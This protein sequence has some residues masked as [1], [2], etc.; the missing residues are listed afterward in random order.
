MSTLGKQILIWFLMFV[1]T[2]LNASSVKATVSDREVIKGDSVLLTITVMGSKIERLPNIQEI[3]GIPV[4]GITRGSSSS[5]IHTNGQ[6]K[7]EHTQTITLEFVPEGN[8]TIPSFQLQVDGVTKST[9]LIELIV[10]DKVVGQKRSNDNFSLEIKVNKEKIYLGE[11]ILIRIY[12]KQRTSIDLMQIDYSPPV[13]K[14]F[15][16]KQLDGEKT[17]R[18]GGY[19]IHELNYLLTAKHEGNLTLES[20]HARVAERNRQRQMGGWYA[21]VPKWSNIHSAPK[22]IEVVKPTVAHDMVGDFRLHVAIDTQKVKANKP[23]NLQ[24]DIRGEGN[25]E[26]Y[27]GLNFDIPNVTMYSDDAKVESRLSAGKLESHYIKSFVFIANHDFTIPSRTIRV[28]NYKTGKV[29][30]LKTKAYRVKVENGTAVATV[31]LVH[32]KQA[33][34]LKSVPIGDDGNENFNMKMPSFVILAITFGLGAISLF[35]VQ[36]LLAYLPSFSVGKWRSKK[37]GFTGHDALKILYPHVG[38]SRE[39]ENMVR[40]LYAIKSGE[41]GIEIDRVALSKMIIKYKTKDL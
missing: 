38:E 11:P 34:A 22:I 17:Y 25:L 16:N 31:P 41:K 24:I 5:F 18:K 39:V 10:L 23:I 1:G 13:F 28:L 14:D 36:Y 40:Q 20:A 12:F 27:D 37:I 3:A 6:S 8:M 15:F 7:M 32:T 4:R 33:V 29:K 19:T 26:D 21:D 35:F 2:F 9:D 30:V